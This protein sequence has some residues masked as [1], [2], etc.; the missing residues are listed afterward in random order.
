[1]T[2]KRIE[3]WWW[4]RAMVYL[5]T[6]TVVFAGL[7]GVVLTG[8]AEPTVDPPH[9]AEPVAKAIKRISPVAG[10]QHEPTYFYNLD[11]DP[12]TYRLVG[13]NSMLSGC[14]STAAY[15][16]V[17]TDS[18]TVIFN[19]TDEGLPLLSYSPHEIL[20]PWPGTLD[21]LALNSANNGGMYL[22]MYKNILGVMRNERDLIGQLTAKQ[23]T[24][25]PE[26]ILKDS[27]GK[28]LIINSHTLAFSDGGSWLVAETLGGSFLRIN[29]ATLEMTAFAASYSRQGSPGLLESRVAISGNGRYV[30][31]ANDV[32]ASFKVYDLATC[33]RA[34]TEVIQN[35]PAYNYWPFAETHIGGLRAIR[36]MRFVND[37]LLSFE[38]RT[39]SAGND[40]IYELAPTATI[41]S[42]IDYLGLGDSYTSGEGAYNYTSGT[43]SATN[44]CHLSAHSYPLLL[45][46]DL[47]SSLGGRSV[48]CSGA[49]IN[50]VSSTSK[51]YRGQVRNV[52]SFEQLQLTKPDLL[53]SVLTNFA[54]G[55]VAQQRFI[56]QYQPAVTTVSIGGD[57][58]GFGDIIQHCVIPHVSRHL[59][60][61]NCYGSYEDRL[62]LTKLIDRTIPRWTALYKQLQAAAPATRLYAIGYPRMVSDT[63][64]CA[65]NA[66][67]GKSELEF[68][69]E[70]I[71]YLN[72]AV[73]QAAA[74]AGVTYV[75]ISQALV[76][77]R[78][79]ETASY[80]V[81]VNGLTAGT[82]GG[83]FGIP[84]FGKESYHPNALG[85]SLMEQA[86]LQQT[87]NLQLRLATPVP[88]ALN[89]QNLL[90]VPKT[91]RTVN[92]LI[93]ESNLTSR[94]IK[95]GTTAALHVDGLRVGLKPRTGYNLLLDGPTG[96]VIA[97]VSSDA[98]GDIT[99][100]ISLPVTT[101][102]GGHTID[103]TGP[104]QADQPVDVT[105]PIYV[106]ASANDSDGD[107]INDTQ[108]SCPLAINSGQDSDQDGIDDSCDGSIGLPPSAGSIST[109][110]PTATV[111]PTT[112][113][114]G[115]LASGPPSGALAAPVPMIV[116]N[117]MIEK[118]QTPTS[119]A[120][121]PPTAQLIG[122]GRVL[123]AATGHPIGVGLQSAMPEA[124]T[125]RV[126]PRPSSGGLPKINMLP[127]VMLPIIGWLLV[128]LLFYVLRLINRKRDAAA[129]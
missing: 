20:V 51:D 25:A 37:R 90:N 63:G 21:V 89:S 116:A 5:L 24:A 84:I 104:N 68:S 75:D 55:Y 121:Q 56:S 118:A 32:A 71:V 27:A 9:W 2:K 103:I 111:T 102:P 13:S 100:T 81:A 12:L 65:A 87:H 11:C 113:G 73:K 109:S 57:D 14:F 82:D 46:H 52:V 108:D 125:K 110:S 67:L 38:A 69:E 98:T 115:A 123:G 86:I 18:G 6:V 43:D 49:I 7:L 112:T 78:L 44:K 76:G 62:E 119:L 64:N 40:G 91:G 79:C 66:H 59:S 34:G 127:L 107:G 105:Q 30:A 23:V 17:D 92:V 77:H 97:T 74:K 50:D 16:L 88:S 19:G 72:N 45:T 54:P 1:M 22:G 28:P 117:F 124:S 42:L 8:A 4:F 31:I 41:D 122:T 99:T 61:S 3:V 35:C 83:P 15:G 95:V 96:K 29:L 58:I 26:L 36:H 53:T 48:A 80:N 120:V 129:I 10:A 101:S 33:G 60:D 126:S 47:F 128:M 85:Q 114:N 39:G 70:L 93:P 106:P 94:V